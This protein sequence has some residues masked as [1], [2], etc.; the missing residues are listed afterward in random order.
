M[1][2]DK[3]AMGVGLEARVP[4]LDHRMVEFAMGIDPDLR[5]RHGRLKHILR[6]AVKDLLPSQL[7]N[8]PKQGFG[9]PLAEWSGGRL[10]ARIRD[11]LERF[12]RRTDLLDADAVR[13]VVSSG[14]SQQGWYL[15]NLALWWERFVSS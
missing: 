9:I 3:M 4:Y 1:R 10:G 2:V 7:L 15:F 12:C 11:T 6:L 8:R 13:R 5:I 14:T